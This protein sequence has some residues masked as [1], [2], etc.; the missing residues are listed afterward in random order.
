MFAPKQSRGEWWKEDI[1]VF[2]IYG[3]SK[4]NSVMDSV[5]VPLQRLERL[6]VERTFLTIESNVTHRERCPMVS[7]SDFIF[8]YDIAKQHTVVGEVSGCN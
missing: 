6:I 7:V 1:S 2:I 8:L 4:G 5:T 3:F